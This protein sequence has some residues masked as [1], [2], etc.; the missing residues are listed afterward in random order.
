MRRIVFA[1]MLAA[2]AA[3]GCRS[4]SSSG[5]IP[6]ALLAEANGK[7]EFVEFYSPT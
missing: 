5:A 2:L 3:T 7:A 1:L 6:S 4:T